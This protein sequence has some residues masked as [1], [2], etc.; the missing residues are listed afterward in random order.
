[1]NTQ[2]HFNSII[3][4]V[5]FF[6]TLLFQWSACSKKMSET[7]PSD[8]T[9]SAPVLFGSNLNIKV[10]LGRQELN[11]VINYLV[12]QNF[13]EGLNY[14]DGYKIKSQLDGPLDIQASQQQIFVQ[15][16]VS[17]EISP[18]GIFSS[19]KVNGAIQ[20]NFTSTFDIVDNK[21][22]FKTELSHHQWKK[23]PVV[24]VL[25]VNLPIEGIGNFI[26][27]KYK[28][29]LCNSIDESITQNIKLDKISNSLHNYFK[30]PVY[31][32]YDNEIHVF[33]NPLDMALGP[34]SMTSQNLEIPLIFYFESVLAD[35]MP[36]EFNHKCSFSVRPHF[37]ARSALNIQSRIPLQFIDSLIQLQIVNQTFG[38]GISKVK[39]KSAHLTGGGNYMYI[40]LNTEGAYRGDLL[41]SFIPE[42]EPGDRK[43]TLQDFKIKAQKGK[44]INKLVFAVVK[45][46]AE[47]KIKKSVEE[48]LNNTLKEFEANVHKMLEKNEIMEGMELN[49]YLKDYSLRKIQFHDNRLYFY[50]NAELE[51]EAIV[52]KIDKDK[53]ILHKF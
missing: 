22:V 30:N 23:K 39:I 40:T 1:M 33:A 38:S 43:I 44:G 37:E 2:S 28:Q 47:L 34:I 15:L 41:L 51:M 18:S 20:L 49:G 16:P 4:R 12:T 46:I 10:K 26:I 31:S 32:Y 17:V 42:F 50:L 11:S 5:L 29:L 36:E 9:T 21:L 25:G 24:N 52:K 6:I 14:E 45:G 3:L 35:S 13:S 53:L 48:Q 7:L 8:L 27:K 19:F